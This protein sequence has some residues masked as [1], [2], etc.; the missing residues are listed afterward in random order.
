M[1]IRLCERCKI[2]LTRFG[3]KIDNLKFMIGYR[4]PMC[5]TKMF[6]EA[7]DGDDLSIKSSP[8]LEKNDD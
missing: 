5:H 6:F 2:A 7:E 3:V 4:C 1:M 8:I